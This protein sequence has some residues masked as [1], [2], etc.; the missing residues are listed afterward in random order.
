[1]RERRLFLHYGDLTD[2]AGL[3]RLL[4]RTEPDEVYH[5]AAQ[6]HVAVS[7]EQPVY[8]LN[9]DALGTARLLEAIH[10][11]GRGTRTYLAGTSE[12][13]GNAQPPQD[14]Y[15]PFRPESPYAAAKLAGYWL[16]V[17]YRDAY[18]EYV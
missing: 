1:V 9:V 5:L 8:T 4:R 10:D 18:G 16:G 6:S 13:F 17:Q 14:E 2:G 3:A 15:T 11:H 12:M 7:F